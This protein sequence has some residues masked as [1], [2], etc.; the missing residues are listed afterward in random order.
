MLLAVKVELPGFPA[1]D[2]EGREVDDVD[3][4]GR[5]KLERFCLQS[6][7]QHA[8]PAVSTAGYGLA[9]LAEFPVEH[10]NTRHYQVDCSYS[11]S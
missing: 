5:L 1:E 9:V 8:G 6:F 3:G 2:G 7:S 11:S 10:R 4:Q